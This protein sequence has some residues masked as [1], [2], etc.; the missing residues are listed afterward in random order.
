M[1]GDKNSTG[2]PTSCT[3]CSSHELYARRVSAKE[4]S[5]PSFLAGLGA[6]FHD[7]DFDVVVCGKCGLTQFF[8]DLPARRDIETHPD[9]RS[10]D[11]RFCQSTDPSAQQDPDQLASDDL[12]SDDVS[13]SLQCLDCGAVIPA[14]NSTCPRCGWTYKDEVPQ[15]EDDVSESSQCLDC[16]AAI[17]AGADACPRCGWTYKDE[18][19]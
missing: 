13:E 4:G 6:S 17:P 19:K 9:W 7:A 18:G 14:G 5:G 8:L 16:G 11:V 3:H 15:D 12:G 2:L 1:N 10:I